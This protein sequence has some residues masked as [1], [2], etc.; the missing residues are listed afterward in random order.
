MKETEMKN[1]IFM[2]IMSAMLILGGS[3]ALADKTNVAPAQKATPA[4]EQPAPK[5]AD[6]NPANYKEVSALSVVANPNSYLGKQIKMK[7]A[8]DKFSTLGLDYKPAYRDAQKYISFLIKRDDVKDHTVPLS[9]MKIFILRTDAEKFIDL[10]SGDIVEIY[11]KV[12]SNA[13]GDPWV[14]VDKLVI[15]EKKTKPKTKA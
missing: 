7:A 10:D 6:I 13:L 1:K 4:K 15:L 2:I 3:I 5:K 11:G 14:D 8:F 12:F 9:E